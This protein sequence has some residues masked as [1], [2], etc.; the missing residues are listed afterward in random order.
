MASLKQSQLMENKQEKIIKY[1]YISGGF[2]S[3]VDC[4][5]SVSPVLKQTFCYLYKVGVLQYD[6][7][8]IGYK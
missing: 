5:Y 8:G 2:S 6:F 3:I 1:D 4:K 7:L